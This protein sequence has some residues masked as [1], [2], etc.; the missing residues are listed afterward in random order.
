[1]TVFKRNSSD[2]YVLLTHSILCRLIHSGKNYP[3]EGGL[4]GC[5]KM[6]DDKENGHHLQPHAS[7]GYHPLTS[8]IGLSQLNHWAVTALGI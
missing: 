8:N 2:V 1:M 6:W 3:G 4:S 7:T 5:L